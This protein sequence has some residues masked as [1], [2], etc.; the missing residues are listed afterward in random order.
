LGDREARKRLIPEQV[1]PDQMIP[2]DRGWLQAA[3]GNHQPV[4]VPTNEAL[5]IACLVRL[6]V[7]VSA[8][9][10]AAIVIAGTGIAQI[11]NL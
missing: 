4:T 9:A 5:P 1:L 3:T 2:S 7:M 6:G 10:S 8:L 11:V